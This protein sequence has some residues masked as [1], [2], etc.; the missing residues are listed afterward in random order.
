MTVPVPGVAKESFTWLQLSGFILLVIGTLVYNEIL[1]IPYFGFD[2]N[3]KAKREKRSK[4]SEFGAG[5]LED[6]DD[7]TNGYVAAS[8]HTAYDASRNHRKIQHKVDVLA[9]QHPRLE[10]GLNKSEITVEE[11]TH[12]SYGAHQSNNY[13]Q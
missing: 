13:E 6:D 10:G 4:R 1:V 8:P 12:K 5:L 11:T 9:H 2:K 7:A 3:V